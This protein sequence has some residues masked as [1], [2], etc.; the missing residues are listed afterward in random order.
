M[1]ET[2]QTANTK[3]DPQDPNP[4]GVGQIGYSWHARDETDGRGVMAGE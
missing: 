3:I 1:G 4:P 2:T